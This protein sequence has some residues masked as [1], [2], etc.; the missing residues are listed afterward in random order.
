MP[1]SFDTP[2]LAEELAAR[3]PKQ[4]GCVLLVRPPEASAME[5]AQALADATGGTLHRVDLGALETDTFEPTLGALREAFDDAH[6]AAVLVLDRAD[7]V[8]SRTEYDDADLGDDPPPPARM[9]AY[10][11]DRASAREGATL[12]VV[13]T[14]PEALA[15]GA[16]ATVAAD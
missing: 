1:L 15:Q 12:V 7:A 4:G 11:L 3:L 10:L 16:A 14:V 9:Q 13:E 2:H 5:V 6:G 8:L